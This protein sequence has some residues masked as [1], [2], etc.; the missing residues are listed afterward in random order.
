MRLYFSTQITIKG[1]NNE[2]EKQVLRRVCR[3]NSDDEKLEV[4][5][6]ER[7]LIASFIYVYDRGERL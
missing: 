6:K 7:I 5:R 3:R 2:T 4:P 1:V